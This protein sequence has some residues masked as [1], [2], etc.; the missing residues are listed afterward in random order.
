MDEYLDSEEHIYENVVSSSRYKYN[1]ILN[2]ILNSFTLKKRDKYPPPP[3]TPPPPTAI[4]QSSSPM[5]MVYDD[6]TNSC[7]FYEN[8]Y[9]SCEDDNIYEN[10]EFF[11]A[12]DDSKFM[13]TDSAL[14]EWMRNLATEIEDYETDNFIFIKSI[15]SVLQTTSVI[16]HRNI[17]KSE[18]TTNFLKALWR[19]DRIG[20]MSFL[21]ETFSSLLRIQSQVT[22]TVVADIKSSSFVQKKKSKKHRPQRREGE[23]Y[24]KKLENVILSSSLNAL[25][26]TYNQSLKFYFALSQRCE[27]F[28]SRLSS[29]DVSSSEAF[30]VTIRRHFK[31]IFYSRRDRRE[32]YRTLE[33]ILAHKLSEINQLKASV[34]VKYRENRESIYQPIW[35]CQ[36]SSCNSKRSAIILNENIY[37]Q[38]VLPSDDNEW[39][40]DDEF[41]FVTSVNN[42]N[43][44]TT[45]TTQN[46]S[47]FRRVWIFYGDNVEQ[48][49]IVYDQESFMH[50]LNSTLVHSSECLEQEEEHKI[51][52]SEKMI[53]DE[54]Y[55]APVEAWKLQLRAPCFMED[56]EDFVSQARINST[57]FFRLTFFIYC[58]FQIVNDSILSA[59]FCS[60]NNSSNDSL[61]S[62]LLSKSVSL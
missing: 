27:A 39:E 54:K 35:T 4:E 24:R 21:L 42:K 9:T 53:I 46:I 19:E 5:M 52:N 2:G 37:A 18:L 22:A 50:S 34:V 12:Y 44:D 29:S 10:L 11:D 26:I 32:F 20:M 16:T 59:N 49:K 38:L 6:N 40:I 61:E 31:L 36:S 28:S 1:K 56:E 14:D 17:S 57:F 62:D 60:S 15:P 23:N 55:L 25:M 7:E 3:T 58:E 51:V 48:N 33:L 43:N 13:H 8:S 30:V 45:M 41:S 47:E